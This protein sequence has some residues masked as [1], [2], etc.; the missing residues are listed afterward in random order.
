MIKVETGTAHQ[1]T[2]IWS[3][4]LNWFRKLIEMQDNMYSKIIY[5]RI[6]TLDKTQS[7]KNEQNWCSQVRLFLE[8]VGY[9]QAWKN[10]SMSKTTI[11][12]IM[13]QYEKTMKQEDLESI[14]HSKYNE[15]YK[16]IKNQFLTEEY[17]N[18]RMMNVPTY[19]IQF[20]SE[21]Q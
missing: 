12:E 21:W 6:V 2:K 17:Q 1:P 7:N 19:K 3:R 18:N 15:Y 4:V 11:R 10:Q 13:A 16:V 8:D 9:E 20:N 5:K 14:S